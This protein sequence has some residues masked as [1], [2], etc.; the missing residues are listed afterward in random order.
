[1]T[2]QAPGDNDKVTEL[3][4]KFE[5]TSVSLHNAFL[6]ISTQLSNLKAT[7]PIDPLSINAT[8]NSIQQEE[9]KQNE[10]EDEKILRD[11][12]QNDYFA[13]MFSFYN[14]LDSLK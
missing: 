10:V 11:E 12:S 8:I 6:E 4:E 7:H 14:N 13:S 9:S 3:I 1:M 5:G 2:T